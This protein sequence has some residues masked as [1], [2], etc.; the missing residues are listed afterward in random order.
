MTWWDKV[1]RKADG[2]A[3]ERARARAGL[4][5]QEQHLP[6]GKRRQG[7]EHWRLEPGCQVPAQLRWLVRGPVVL[8]ALGLAAQRGLTAARVQRHGLPDS[9]RGWQL[10][11]T[12][13]QMQRRD[14]CLVQGRAGWQL[15][16][17]LLLYLV[18]C[19]LTQEQ[20]RAPSRS[21]KN[22]AS[23]VL[24]QA[25]HGWAQR[26]ESRAPAHLHSVQFEQLR[27]WAL[28][29]CVRSLCLMG[30]LLAGSIALQGTLL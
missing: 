14:E 21:A 18:V 19:R 12:L 1:R 17:A 3:W 10:A 16:Q 24:A 30:M 15:A 20:G 22:P 27:G 5:R 11:R 29:H 23:W 7:T 13:L 2:V 26:S 4:G 9:V 25:R 8:P 28:L 6:T